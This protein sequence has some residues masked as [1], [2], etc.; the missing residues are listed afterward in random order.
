MTDSVQNIDTYCNLR[1]LRMQFNVPPTRLRI[2]SPYSNGFTKHEI[3]M[4]RKAEIL[5][6]QGP[7]KSTQMNTLTKKQKFAQVIRGY[8]PEQKTVRSSNFTEGQLAFCNSKE[9]KVLS[10]SSDVPGPA[11]PLFL[12]KSVPLYNYTVGNRTYAIIPD[13]KQT[14]RFFV[15]EENENSIQTIIPFVQKNIG[16][17]EIIEPSSSLIKYKLVISYSSTTTTTTTTT[18]NTVN[19]AQL[20]I[21]YGGSEIMYPTTFEYNI[22]DENIIIDNIVLYTNSGYFYELLLTINNYESITIKNF[23]L[24]D[25]I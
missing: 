14:W 24:T 12:D 21:Y 10:T 2:L 8:N 9:N 15:N 19:N 4:R 17:L 18:T 23:T 1:K 22:D 16:T 7:Q 11:I 20:Q 13:E 25:D 6:H 3:D 5:K